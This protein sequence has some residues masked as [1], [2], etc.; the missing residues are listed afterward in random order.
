MDNTRQTI[1]P[2]RDGPGAAATRPVPPPVVVEVDEIPSTAAIN[3][4]PIHPMVIVFPIA[5]LVGALVT[6]V[7]YALVRDAFWADASLGLVLVGVFSGVVAAVFGAVDFFT[8]VRIRRLQAAWIHAGAN[9]IALTAA[10]IS[11]VVRLEDASAGV[12][13]WG[14][15]LSLVTALMLMVS[16]WFG[17]ELVYRHKVGVDTR[18]ISRIPESE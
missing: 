4:H 16:G 13:P 8:R 5:A 14:L 3:G 11:L 2:A 10:A 1:S 6:D 15:L 7:I 9:V 12:L 18:A 17:G